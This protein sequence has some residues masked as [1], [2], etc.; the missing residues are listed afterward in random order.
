MTTSKSSLGFTKLYPDS[1]P[2]A[3][4]SGGVDNNKVVYVNPMQFGASAL[5]KRRINFNSYKNMLK[6]YKPKEK[7][8]IMHY[9]N[10]IYNKNGD[11][12]LKDSNLNLYNIYNSI[13][14]ADS[15]LMSFDKIILPSGSYF[16]PYPV[17]DCFSVTYCFGPAG[18]GKSYYANMYA[19]NY[20]KMYPDN[21]VY[22]V[23]HQEAFDDPAF[24][25]LK[26]IRLNI[27]KFIANPP[28]LDDFMD[29]LVIFDDYENIA[30][31]PLNIIIHNLID[32]IASL[33]RKKHIS[34][35]CITH[36]STNYKK[37]NYY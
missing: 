2:I 16:K 4:I 21:K 33:G 28:L 25:D 11:N 9:F 1:C 29:S 6:G 19:T 27:N 36:L 34:A 20:T 7:D 13:I 26:I 24:E 35:F 30:P 3:I 12:D 31:K 32:N 37:L 5:K 15:K 10:S 23:T 18:S 8:E 14:D 22:L 17:G